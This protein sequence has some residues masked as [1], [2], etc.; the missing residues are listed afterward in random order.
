MNAV[1]PITKSVSTNP[2]KTSAPLGAALAWLGVDGA[3]PLFHGSQGCTAFAL[4]LLVRHFKEMIPLQTTAMNEVSTIVGGADHVEEAL[5]NLKK[6]MNPRFIGIC[7]TALTETRGED[8][9]GDLRLIRARREEELKGV[10]VVFASTP[11][12][13]GAMEEGWAKAVTATIETLVPAGRGATVKGQV[14]VLAGLH[15]SPADVEALRDTIESFG[16]KPIVLPDLSCSLD[17][18]VADEWR[19]TARGGVTVEEIAAM[20]R[21]EAT[22]VI[23]EHMRAPGQALEQ[24]AGVPNLWFDHLTGIEACDRLCVELAHLGHCSVPPRLRRERARLVD[25][26]LDGHFFFAGRKMAVAAEPDLLLATTR[27]M[28]DLGAEIS[29][30]ITTTAGSTALTQIPAREVL[31]GDLGDLEARAKGADLI[32]THS[33]GRQA[34]ERLHVPHLRIGFPIFDRL[35]AAY[36]RTALYDGSRQA[37]FEIANLFQADHREVTPDSLN[38]FLLRQKEMRA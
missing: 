4:V 12:F 36:R 3:V 26:M 10:E 2:L 31:V 6:R 23:G 7:S 16:L 38:P 18:A 11:D 8:F 32:A 9:V 20:G 22:L 21:S 24:R 1:A 5:L 37:I 25:V 17:G 14:N 27:L 35:G 30:A 13:S 19:A 28:H 15:L 34:A 33:H 29:A